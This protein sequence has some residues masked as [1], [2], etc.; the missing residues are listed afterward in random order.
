MRSMPLWLLRDR[1]HQEV[2]LSERYDCSLVIKTMMEHNKDCSGARLPCHDG[3]AIAGSRTPSRHRLFVHVCEQNPSRIV[4]TLVVPD[5]QE[6][7][8]EETVLDVRCRLTG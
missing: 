5:L 7:P 6:M 4:N 8:S 1:S 3:I 2:L